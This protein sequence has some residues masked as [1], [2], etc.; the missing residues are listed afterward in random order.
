MA[1][2]YADKI[3]GRAKAQAMCKADGGMVVAT[4]A[5]VNE[6]FPGASTDNPI[7]QSRT[8]HFQRQRKDYSSEPKVG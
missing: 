5:P 8:R 6:Q 1:H 7:D 2:P 4:Q 3:P